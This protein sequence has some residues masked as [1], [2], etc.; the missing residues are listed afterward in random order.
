[1]LILYEQKALEIFIT[2]F[3]LVV[4]VVFELLTQISVNFIFIQSS[5]FKYKKNR[6]NFQITC[7][8]DKKWYLDN[9]FNPKPSNADPSRNCTRAVFFLQ[10]LFF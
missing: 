7:K 9:C 1:M 3:I 5:S 2:D 6:Y 8:S 4:V 10:L